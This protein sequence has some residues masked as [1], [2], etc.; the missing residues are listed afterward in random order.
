QQPGA[1]PRLAIA[2]VV[3]TTDAVP[4]SGASVTLAPAAGAASTV[5]TA[6][7][8]RFAFTAPSGAAELRV[9][10]IGFRAESLAVALPI[11]PG[12][13]VV[14]RL[15]FVPRTLDAVVVQGRG[16]DRRPPAIVEFYERRDRGNGRF[17]TRAEIDRRQPMRTT[18]LLRT[19][20]GIRVQL[21]G[22]GT[23]L[24]YRDSR[25]APEV[26]LDGLALSAGEFDV[27]AIAPSTIEGIE[28]HSTS[29]VPVQY[30]RAFGRAS[31][32]TVLLWSRYGEPRSARRAKQPITSDSLARLVAQ[33]QL[34]SAEQVDTPA[35]PPA[36]FGRRVGLPDTVRVQGAL[37]V[38]AEFV[39]DAA[40]RVE[41]ATIN[42]VASPHPAL[43]DA[44]RAAL[45]GAT[46]TPA[47]RGG[48]TVRQLVQLSVRFDDVGGGR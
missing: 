26:Y 27:D 23:S 34:F 21:T 37:A 2:G 38:I 19:V 28:V 35:Q 47:R 1:S 9:R 44:V 14:V 40:G 16:T 10:R 13:S 32:G 36:D 33:L 43:A 29:T 39:V 8:G 45:P 42:V 24:R 48:V 25:C 11:A 7:D 20:P 17:I 31:C 12:D 4:I 15:A 3:V 18:D 30:T 5:V 22:A 46:F 41:P 6:D